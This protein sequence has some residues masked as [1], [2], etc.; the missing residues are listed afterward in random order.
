MSAH[1]CMKEVGCVRTPIFGSLSPCGLWKHPYKMYRPQLCFE[2][3][4]MFMLDT[5]MFCNCAASV[6]FLMC[7]GGYWQHKERSFLTLLNIEV[8]SKNE[9]DY[10]LTTYEQT[11]KQNYKLMDSKFCR[12][13]V[14]LI[15]PLAPQSWDFSLGHCLVFRP[16]AM[17]SSKLPHTPPVLPHQK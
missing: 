17:R 15:W 4:K 7:D 2:W 3:S 11:G 12:A 9:K 1:T 14:S 8:F 16:C 5:K 13:S 6:C 10:Y